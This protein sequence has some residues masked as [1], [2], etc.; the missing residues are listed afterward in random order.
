MTRSGLKVGAVAVLLFSSA[1]P[2]PTTLPA[3][4]CSKRGITALLARTG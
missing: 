3:S 4:C 2:S 1:W